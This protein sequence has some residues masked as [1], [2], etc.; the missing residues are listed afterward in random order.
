M[1]N[2]KMMRKRVILV[3]I[4]LLVMTATLW[5]VIQWAV[6]GGWPSSG[7]VRGTLPPNI[8]YVVPADGMTV[9]DSYGICVQFNYFAG[10]GI[11]DEPEKSIRFYLDGKNVTRSVVDVVRL[12]YGYPSPSGEPCYKRSE[13]L[14]SGWHTA[15]VTFKYITGE[16]FEYKWRFEV[17]TQK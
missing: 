11:E 15:K 9:E 12:E 16:R 7:A 3:I 8:Q 17:N 14:R 4:G 13:P 6:N 2:E 5:I 10:H 1:Y